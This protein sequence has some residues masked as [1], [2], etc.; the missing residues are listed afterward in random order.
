[1]T[2]RPTNSMLS[3]VERECANSKPAAKRDL[4]F[5]NARLQRLLDVAEQAATRYTM[6][7][8][9][10]DHRIKNSLQIVVNLM[11][12]QA[13]RE[14]N[15]MARAALRAAAA[16]IQ[17]VARIHDALQA[18]GG[19]DLVDLGE[20]LGK[21]CEGLH[22]MAGDPL[23]VAIFVNVEQ[24]H[25]PMAL[26]QPV[27]LAVNELVVNALRHAFPGDRTGSI[28]ISV[29]QVG[30][31][32]HVVVADDGQGLPPAYAGGSGYG[33]R[34]VRMMAEQIR[35]ALRIEGSPGSRFTL[36]APANVAALPA[37]EPGLA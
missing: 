37:G 13:A 9:E 11:G 24:I 1:M 4:D 6:M 29:A 2:E 17:S 35:G 27:V 16:R 5:E 12:L 28:W 23:K 20:V 32:L 3:G 8:R 10:G 33:M 34:L 7:L 19:Q 36:V 22:A 14:A 25:V 21:M 26:A 15:D 31:E 30:G 18:S